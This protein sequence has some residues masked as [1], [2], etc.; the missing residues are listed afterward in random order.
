MPPEPN[1]LKPLHSILEETLRPP[2]SVLNHESITK[3][4]ALWLCLHPVCRK[5]EILRALTRVLLSCV[6]GASRYV[7]AWLRSD[8]VGWVCL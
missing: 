2:Q 8:A 3:M 6:A 1:L 7:R 4:Y 5:F